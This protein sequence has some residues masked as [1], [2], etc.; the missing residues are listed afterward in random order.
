[1][2]ATAEEAIMRTIVLVA[3]AM[4][5]LPFT[6]IDA[7]ADAPW[8]AYDVG[9]RTNCGFYSYEQCMANLSGIGGSCLPNPAFQ[10]NN[11]RGRPPAR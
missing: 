7:R 6:S 3:A 8:C 11:N 4:T 1:M 10:G 2:G 9:G 5:V